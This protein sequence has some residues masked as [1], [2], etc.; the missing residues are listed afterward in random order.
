MN[1]SAK[2]NKALE[3]MKDINNSLDPNKNQPVRWFHQSELIG[4]T[5]HTLKALKEKGL[6]EGIV[7][8]P[9]LQM[10]YRIK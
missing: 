10:Y 7:A 5:L 1:L 8:E 9:T 2:Q 3:L 6:I 4:I